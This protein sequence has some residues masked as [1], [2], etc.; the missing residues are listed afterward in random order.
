MNKTTISD[1][2]YA[3]GFNCTSDE[4][5]G[6]WSSERLSDSRELRGDI[7]RT[8]RLNNNTLFSILN[9]QRLREEVHVGFG[10]RVDG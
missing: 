3:N 7:V 8:Q 4:L 6:S 5:I 2:L 10:R 1:G 9:T